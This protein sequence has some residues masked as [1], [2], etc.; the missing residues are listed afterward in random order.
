MDPEDQSEAGVWPASIVLD[1]VERSLSNSS[2]RRQL[3]AP[4][5][6]S[7]ERARASVD[8]PA[9]MD[10]WIKIVVNNPKHVVSSM[11]ALCSGVFR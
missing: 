6:L 10:V 1:L 3:R 2:L 4:R 7:G 9:T 8:T 5:R 11:T